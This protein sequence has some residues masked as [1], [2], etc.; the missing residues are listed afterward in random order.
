M[1]EAKRYE[2]LQL[3]A[4]DFARYANTDELKVMLLAKLPVNLCDHKG[5]TLLMLSA[6]NG[7]A[8]TTKMLIEMG[9]DVNRKNDRGQ[10]PLEG[11]CFKGYLDIA[12]LLV[13]NGAAVNGTNAIMCASIFGNH[14]IVKYLTRQKTGFKTKLYLA[15]AKFIS[16]FKRA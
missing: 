7:N 4:L 10:T 3:L 6:Y 1:D 9:A 5:N 2:E 8:D 11:V 14:N 15:L 13:Q 12:K 16:L